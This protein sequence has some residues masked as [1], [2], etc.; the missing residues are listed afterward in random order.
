MSVHDVSNA[1]DG[2]EQQRYW[3]RYLGNMYRSTWINNHGMYLR[4]LRAPESQ[5]SNKHWL[6]VLPSIVCCTHSSSSPTCN[7]LTKQTPYFGF[8]KK[9]KML[10]YPYIRNYIHRPPFLIL[11]LSFMSSLNP[12]P[13]PPQAFPSM[14]LLFPAL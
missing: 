8:C 6:P 5:N 3:K 4:H 13:P 9:N 1:L 2:I 12:T 10:S 14:F 7:H 11:F